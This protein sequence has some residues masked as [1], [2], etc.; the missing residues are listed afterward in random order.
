MPLPYFF[1]QKKPPTLSA[2]QASIIASTAA[3]FLQ[4]PTNTIPPSHEFPPATSVDSLQLHLLERNIQLQSLR[5]LP[6]LPTDP[7][8]ATATTLTLALSNHYPSTTPVP[9]PCTTL[10]VLRY[11][12]PSDIDTLS[13]KPSLLD[14]TK[15]PP[16]LLFTPVTPPPA[17]SGQPADQTEQSDT[18]PRETTPTPADPLYT[19]TP[20]LNPTL[21]HSTKNP[22]LIALVPL[23]HQNTVVLQPTL[24]SLA[25]IKK[26]F[27]HLFSLSSTLQLTPSQPENYQKIGWKWFLSQL[28]YDRKPLTTLLLASLFIQILALAT[29]LA[30]QAIVDKVISNQ[31]TNTLITLGIGTF[32][33]N[34]FSALLSWS[35]QYTILQ[36]ANVLD[37]RISQ[38]IIAHL[39]KLPLS[40]FEKARTGSIINRIR[41][42]EPIREF[43]TG[44]FTTTLIDLPFL[45]IFLALM[46]S[47]SPLLTTIVLAVCAILCI[48]SL[49]IGPMFQAT[50]HKSMAVSAHLQGQLTEQL[51]AIET[52]KALQ[53]EPNS[54]SQFQKINQVQLDLNQNLRQMANTFQTT[55]SFLE[56]TLNLSIL[57][58]GAYLT[59]TDTTLTI[60]MLLAFQMF[61]QRVTQP[62]LK[63]TS[64]WQQYQQTR[65]SIDQLGELLN[66]EPENYSTLSTTLTKPAGHL[67]AANLHFQYSALSPMLIKNLSFS[68]PPKTLATLEGPSGSGKSTLMKMIQGHLHPTSG[69][70]TLDGRP[71]STIPVQE[72]RSFFGVVPQESI[73]FSGS[74]LD[75]LLLA[76][77]G[78]SFPQIVHTCKLAD[79]H[80]TIQKMPQG[81]STILG[82]RGSGLSGGQKQRIAIARALLRQ[83]SILLFDEALSALDDETAYHIAH[84]INRLKSHITIIYISHKNPPNLQIDQRIPVNGK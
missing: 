12:S 75:N 70:L 72:L 66:H 57:A 47:Y 67:V 25:Y 60:G 76:N 71:I 20:L 28:T 81:Y 53:L 63:I 34:L 24:T 23:S 41:S 13:L 59:M 10:F 46:L 21:Y 18:E 27:P 4:K 14:L 69:E 68:V 49:L 74:I 45:F 79:I 33:L 54:L 32:V 48:S 77:P 30:T 43:L 82:E 8:P 61:S 3:S 29:P 15:T 6:P 22:Y 9:T 73:L 80:D 16:Q 5:T 56:Q 11:A 37:A 44:V 62:L 2:T 64:L 38:Q 52:I 78:A 35:R 51:T 84:T 83:P 55:N 17:P 26:Y 50:A 1:Q 31:A 7:N 42:L 58:I 36:T 39:F 40:Y 19:A 65:V